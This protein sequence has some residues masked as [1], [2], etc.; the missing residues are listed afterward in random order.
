MI[1]FRPMFNKRFQTQMIKFICIT[2]TSAVTIRHLITNCISTAKNSETLVSV[3]MFSRHGARTPLYLVDGL[4]E[5]EYNL[6]LLE[7]F[8]KAR[9]TLKTLENE[10]LCHKKASLYDQKNLDRKLKGGAP[11]GQLTKVGEKQMFELG[12]RIREKYVDQ[13]KFLEPGYTPSE[14]YARSSHFRRTIN[15]ARCVLAGV[16][17]ESHLDECGLPF[18]INVHNLSEDYIFPNAI[19][20]EYYQQLHASFKKLGLFTKDEKFIKNLNEL[21]RKIPKKKGEENE[22][23]TF[24]RFRDDMIAR[25][26]HNEKVPK[27]FEID[28]ENSHHYASKELSAMSTH[29]LKISCGRLL[30]MIKTNL[31]DATQQA[32]EKQLHKFRYYSVHDTTLNALLNAF[33]MIDEENQQWPPFAA[34]IIIE[35]WKE[36]AKPEYF[37]KFFYC[38]EEMKFKGSRG[39]FTLDQFVKMLEK[40]EANEDTYGKLCS[41]AFI[42]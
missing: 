33:E 8:V 24:T 16:Y 7:P 2:G 35:L 34:D 12:R 20:C 11:M 29:D 39:K 37:V 22:W 41:R 15:S 10:D 25:Q 31:L 9:Y 18:V 26:I 3:H 14:F 36:E 32:A 27:H 1:Q 42:G 38:G 40:N 6:S 30:H 5:V 28:L 17:N 19:N 23:I 13:M 4:E 21:N